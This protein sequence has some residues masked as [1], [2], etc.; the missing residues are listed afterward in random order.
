MT[1]HINNKT[2]S[3]LA[4]YTVSLFYNSNKFYNSNCS[5]QIAITD[6]Y[7]PLA[8]RYTVFSRQTSGMKREHSIALDKMLRYFEAIPWSS[9]LNNWNILV[10]YW[11]L[12]VVKKIFSF[13]SVDD[14]PDHFE[15]SS[16]IWQCNIYIFILWKLTKMKSSGYEVYLLHL[17]LQ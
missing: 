3:C 2:L 8:V 4:R 16:V 9:V 12:E 6:K 11:P 17:Q 15:W 13:L 5:K 1:Y 10:L 7:P 14:T